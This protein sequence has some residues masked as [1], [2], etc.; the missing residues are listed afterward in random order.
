MQS[1][2]CKQICSSISSER[3]ASTVG[4]I[5]NGPQTGV[6]T[7]EPVGPFSQ[8]AERAIDEVPSP[9]NARIKKGLSVPFCVLPLLPGLW[10]LSSL[11]SMP[12]VILGAN[13]LLRREMRARNTSVVTLYG[14]PT[15]GYYV[16]TH[17]RKCESTCKS[18]YF[19]EIWARGGS[20]RGAK[21]IQTVGLG[22]AKVLPGPN[23]DT[24]AALGICRFRE[25]GRGRECS[26]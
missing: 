22:W 14:T 15:A 8:L 6:L 23:M 24:W 20:R 2:R 9:S 5:P 10:Q 13:K 1:K 19:I 26:A 11:L 7:S 12:W 18:I 17:P 16:F 25:A 21:G 4:G 3:S